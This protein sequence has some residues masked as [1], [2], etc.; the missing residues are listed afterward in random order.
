[1]RKSLLALTVICTLC[2][3]LLLQTGKAQAADKE[4]SSGTEFVELDPLILPIIDGNGLAQTLSIV[5]AIEV[6]NSN[7]ASKVQKIKPRLKDA[8]IEHLYGTLN[9]HAT[10]RGGMLR[11][12]KIKASL[13]KITDKVMGD[14]ENNGVLLQVVQ[15]RPL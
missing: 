15:E 6:P 8:Y 4:T 11:I 9:R 3:G 7:A 2:A 10:Y 12:S 5:I 1:M 14:T 13:N